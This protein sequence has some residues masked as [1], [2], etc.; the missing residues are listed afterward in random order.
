MTT[1]YL[2]FSILEVAI[3]SGG[4]PFSKNVSRI[5]VMTSQDSYAYDEWELYAP[6]ALNK[7]DAE[8]VLLDSVCSTNIPSI[9]DD[10]FAS[11]ECVANGSS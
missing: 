2:L 9:I 4:P 11:W 10:V 8:E 3:G 1:H 7:D 5:E 6:L